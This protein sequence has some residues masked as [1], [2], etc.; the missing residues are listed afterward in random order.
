MTHVTLNNFYLQSFI[1]LAAAFNE[2]TITLR[3]LR[4]Q[5]RI[6]LIIL[7]SGVWAICSFTLASSKSVKVH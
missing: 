5:H 7:L 1:C 6:V 4:N 3:A 2:C